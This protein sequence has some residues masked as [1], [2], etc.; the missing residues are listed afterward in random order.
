MRL[1]IIAHK[2]FDPVFVTL[3]VAICAAFA[4]MA[5]GS[6]P[7]TLGLNVVV[8]M[9]MCLF[10]FFGIGRTNWTRGLMPLRAFTR[11][12]KK[13]AE[14]IDSLG[15]Q[16]LD[17]LR[18]VFLSEE[19]RFFECEGLGTALQ[20][21]FAESD[22]LYRQGKQYYNCDIADYI[23]SDLANDVGNTAFSDFL[24]SVLTGLGILGTF[25]GLAI[26]L[27][28]FN[29][30]S[31]EAMTNSIVP[32]IEGIKI[33][34]YTSIFGVF[35]SLVYGTLYKARLNQANVAVDQFVT[36]F[37]KH[38]GYNP[39]NDAIARV[40]QIQEDQR[41]TMNQFAENIS[42][43]FE[44][45]VE[46]SLAPALSQL[47]E[48]IS[49]AVQNTITP[50]M[51]TM[52]NSFQ[53]LATE[54][55]ENLCHAQ[56]N[57][58]ET[59]VDQFLERMNALMGTQIENLG[60]SIQSICDWQETTSVR[61]KEV[62]ESVCTN[63][64]TLSTINESLEKSVTS[65]ESYIES[66][67]NAQKQITTEFAAASE[68]FGKNLTAASEQ[69]VSTFNSSSA[70]IGQNFVSAS[71][72]M[73]N[74]FGAAISASEQFGKNLTA[75][76]EQIIFTF[77]SASDQMG[78]NFASASE[79]ITST[80]NSSSAQIGQ[81]FVSA[82][83]QISE[84]FSVATEKF[85]QAISAVNELNEKTNEAMSEH[86]RML[87]TSEKITAQISQ[88]QKSVSELSRQQLELIQSCS[89]KLAEQ[90]ESIKQLC[91]IIAGDMDEAANKLVTVSGQLSNDVSQ[92][93]TRTYA[94]FDSQLAKAIEHF[95][96]TL[97]EL[98]DIVEK[99]PKVV[100][101]ASDK[102]HKELNTC[103]TALQNESVQ[104]AKRLENMAQ[105]L[106]AHT[107]QINNAIS[108]IKHMVD[109]LHE[110]NQTR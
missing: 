61:L 40:L 29:A 7:L 76:S 36:T 42:L 88:Q 21:Y 37:Y 48:Q 41:D 39:E 27:Q 49:V 94:Q 90:T 66:I 33:A 51:Q 13:A 23:H 89:A 85:D 50:S 46:N 87:E 93:M 86:Q 31:A 19:D 68:Q 34:F 30:E 54:L 107:Q 101:G 2:L 22:S 75:A 52:G 26:G 99:T 74:N 102:L 43:A 78:Q 104:Q 25:V 38:T 35:L 108:Q 105:Q 65:M 69:I 20:E 5:S 62:V 55:T 17:A 80:F 58:V 3:C 71:E 4:V 47:P 32:L 109:S 59:I 98:R 110:T 12:L 56:N 24:S 57:G 103:L 44:N 53:T 82:S 72:Q 9:I 83:K 100:D 16:D 67:D 84:N 1:K 11:D 96:G 95:S 64:E 14:H 79:K 8:L 15:D 28:S 81:N 97:M 106:S 63:A 91:S 10:L 73:S 70:Q 6:E 18:E 60:K 77:A 92:A 45:V